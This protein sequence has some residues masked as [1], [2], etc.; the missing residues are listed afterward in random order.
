MGYIQTVIPWVPVLPL[1]GAIFLGLAGKKIFNRFGEDITGIIGCITP[2]VSSVLA[3][4][5]FAVL[6]SME[7]SSRVMQIHV[8]DWISVAD[9]QI[10]WTFRYDP[11]SAVMLMIVTGIGTLIHIYGMGYMHGDK[12]FSRFFS[13]MNLFVAAMLMLVLGDNIII[14]FLGWEGV[15]LCSY[16]LI[17]FWF[18]EEA[19]AVAGKKA[20]ITNRIGDLGFIVGIFLLVYYSSSMF[21]EVTLSF[22]ELQG[23][24]V[25]LSHMTF[26]GFPCW[27]WSACV[28]LSGQWEN[29]RRF[30]YMSGCRMRWPVRHLSAR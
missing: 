1:F 3:F 28:S 17:G 2:M 6:L 18:E 23:R 21:G 19:N 16:L 20:F 29:R 9:V 14:M 27:R 10:D 8:M 7:P 15:G 5:A 11:L 30:P 22:D 26:A 13:Y 25:E 12:S 24:A 4:S